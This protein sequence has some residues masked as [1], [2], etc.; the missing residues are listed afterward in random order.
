MRLP[1]DELPLDSTTTTPSPTLPS[2]TFPTQK[3]AIFPRLGASGDSLARLRSG[4]HS[5]N[6]PISRPCSPR[7]NPKVCLSL[8]TGDFRV[9]GTLVNSKITKHSL[10]QLVKATEIVA[11]SGEKQG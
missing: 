9:C 7:A 11:K 3:L 8:I 6:R 2:V 4:P 10:I 1:G 5:G